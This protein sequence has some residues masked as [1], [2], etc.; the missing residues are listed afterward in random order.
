[1]LVFGDLVMVHSRYV[2]QR[3]DIAFISKANTLIFLHS[4]F[5]FPDHTKLVILPGSTRNASPWVDFYHLSASAARYLSGEGRMHPSGF[6]TR[7]VVSE[8]ATILI[9]IA[10]GTYS[11]TV[12]EGLREILKANSFLPKIGFIKD[13]LRTWIKHGRLGGRPSLR[14]DSS[15]G[16]KDGRALQLETHWDGAQE[17]PQQ[18]GASAKFVWVTV[19]APGGDGEYRAVSLKG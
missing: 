2:D 6:D 10:D 15:A 16:N 13:V 14:E 17:R 19:G 7:A 12:N 1:M 8:E 5:N 3:K 18:G 4:Q 11:N 9:S